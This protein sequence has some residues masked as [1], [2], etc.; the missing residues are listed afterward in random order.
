MT[1][2]VHI[3]TP[4]L[5]VTP[6]PGSGGAIIDVPLPPAG[7]AGGQGR[8]THHRNK[9]RFDVPDGGGTGVRGTG[10]MKFS[11][12]TRSAPLPPMKYVQPDSDTESEEE[13]S[14][15]IKS[16]NNDNK[17]DF[18]MTEAD[19]EAD[20]ELFEIVSPKLADQNK[21]SSS[22]CEY[23]PS[24]RYSNHPKNCVSPPTTND[25]DSCD[26]YLRP[27]SQF[28]PS[29][30]PISDFSEEE[31]SE[32]VMD[33]TVAEQLSI[34][35]GMWTTSGRH[36]VAVVGDLVTFIAPED[37]YALTIEDGCIGLLDAYIAMVVS[38]PGKPEFIHWDDGDIWKRPLKKKSITVEIA[39]DNDANFVKEK[40]LSHK[41]CQPI[42]DSLKY[43]G[44]RG[45][46]NGIGIDGHH[47]Y[48]QVTIDELDT[49]W[50][51]CVLYPCVTV[52]DKKANEKERQRMRSALKPKAEGSL[53][54]FI[55]CFPH[56][57]KKRHQKKNETRHSNNCTAFA[58]LLFCVIVLGFIVIV[59]VHFLKS[60]HIL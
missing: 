13:D 53:N 41:A 4:S 56:K 33:D 48:A 27:A 46:L 47:I 52:P 14:V 8:R 5:R 34:L 6:P 42:G 2:I 17:E 1:E 7:P 10:M 25:S 18:D 30:S 9:V 37:V 22:S 16:S 38:T 12:P 40:C 57:K 58:V 28:N 20:D 24:L 54:P 29:I 15:M 32:F 51:P 43:C 3:P 59:V 36:L 45:Y 44:K 11:R 35:Q 49:L 19:R 26:L 55:L 60:N 23:P 21:V 39:I 50:P 31:S